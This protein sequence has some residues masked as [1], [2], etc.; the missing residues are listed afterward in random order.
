MRENAATTIIGIRSKLDNRD[1]SALDSNTKQA[2][3]LDLE[4]NN[5]KSKAETLCYARVS[6]KATL[7]LLPFPRHLISIAT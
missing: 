5:L 6:W 4:M 2:K 3:K 7:S 1:G